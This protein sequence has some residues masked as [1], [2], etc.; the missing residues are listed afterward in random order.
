MKKDDIVAVVTVAGE[1]VGKYHTTIDGNVHLNDPRMLIQ[2]QQGM[3][4]AS[5][6]CVTGQMN[7]DSVIFN[8]Y[9]FITPVNEDIEKAYR[10]AV[11]GL[12]L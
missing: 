9:V 10:G 1:F 5:G 4:F 11:S 2:N 8:D 7:P 6:I 12:V 3:G